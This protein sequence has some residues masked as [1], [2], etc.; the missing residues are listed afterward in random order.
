M[1]LISSLSLPD[2]TGIAVA[3]DMEF[4]YVTN[5]SDNTMSVVGADPTNANFHKELAR[6]STGIGPRALSVQPENEDIFVCDF[7]GNTISIINSAS[8]TIRKQLTSLVN[9]PFD[10]ETTERQEQPGAPH[11]FGWASGIYFGYISNLTGN[12]VVV[13]RVGQSVE[14]ASTASAA[15]PDRR[16]QAEAHRAARLASRRSPTPR[17]CSRAASSSHTGRSGVPSHPVHAAG[18]PGRCRSVTRAHPA[19]IHRSPVR[20]H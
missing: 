8:L 13:D 19:R 2:P 5:F 9:G 18:A 10:V 4:V 20:G 3:P 7:L 16:R 1:R 6:V 12:S 14:S 17:A 11:P 15:P